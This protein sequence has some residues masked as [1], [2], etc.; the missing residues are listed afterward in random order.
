MVGGDDIPGLTQPR[1]H[2][3]IIDGLRRVVSI[4]ERHRITLILE[5]MNTRVDHR[6][7]CLY[8]SEAGVR[9]V[10]AV[11]SR[12]VKVLFDLYHM[13]ISEGDLCGHIREG[14]PHLGYVQIADHP[15]RNDPGT[16]EIHFPRVLCQ[17]YECGYRGYV[18]LEAAPDPRRRRGGASVLPGG[19]VVNV[20]I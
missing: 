1:M 20:V 7:H 10:R 5:P 8:G 4:V 9:I 15:G 16:G 14:F 3:N 11:N 19:F 2:D 17:L 6:G 13:S 12:Y 18:G